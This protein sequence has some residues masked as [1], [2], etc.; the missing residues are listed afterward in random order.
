MRRR[1]HCVLTHHSALCSLSRA[2]IATNSSA[3]ENN[4][5]K[6]IKTVLC[7]HKHCFSLGF[8]LELFNRCIFF[9][10][11][12]L[13]LH[14][15]KRNSSLCSP[16]RSSVCIVQPGMGTQSLSCSRNVAKFHGLLSWFVRNYRFA[17]SQFF[18]GCWSQASTLCD[19]DT[20][21]SKH[22]C[23]TCKVCLCFLLWRDCF[24]EWP[25]HQGR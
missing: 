15:R 17:A 25:T 14:E 6:L 7:F 24:A 16:E 12:A 8:F 11:A 19:H 22:F 4:F 20:T 1:R 2:C 13:F 9:H 23:S 10:T 18:M 21:Q 3:P 5:I